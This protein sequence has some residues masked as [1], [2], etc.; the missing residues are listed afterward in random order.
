MLLKY[1]TV[2][3][4]SIVAGVAEVCLVVDTVGCDLIVLPRLLMLAV[5]TF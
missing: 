1:S 2:L 5:L 4:E 3:M